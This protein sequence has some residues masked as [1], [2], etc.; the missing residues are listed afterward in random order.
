[1]WVA[2]LLLSLDES[3]IPLPPLVLELRLNASAD[4]VVELALVNRSSKPLKVVKPGDGSNEGWR[5]PHVYWT[6]ETRAPGGVWSPLA[7]RRYARC[8]NYAPNWEKDVVD[9]APGERLVLSGW[10]RSPGRVFDLK[11]GTRIRLVAHYDYRAAPPTKARGEEPPSVPR[12]DGPMKGVL[13][14]KL[15]SKAVEFEVE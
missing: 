4:P 7:P 12:T 13:P 9:L 15:A 8:G 1:M 6:A 5:E 3:N 2:L 11:P 10:V 14:F